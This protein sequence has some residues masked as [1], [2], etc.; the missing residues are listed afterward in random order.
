MNELSI[1]DLNGDILTFYPDGRRVSIVGDH[2][3]AHLSQFDPNNASSN[4]L[5]W[6][7]YACML[8]LNSPEIDESQRQAILETKLPKGIKQKFQWNG[9]SI[10]IDLWNETYP[11]R[12]R[13]LI[14]LVGKSESTGSVRFDHKNVSIPQ[15]FRLK[16]DYDP[17]TVTLT[18]DWQKR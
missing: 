8:H 15:N 4:F 11:P 16:L 1:I 13:E 2:E 9:K 3:Q 12:Y 14:D 5:P 10:H 18:W 7:F 6:D 17:S